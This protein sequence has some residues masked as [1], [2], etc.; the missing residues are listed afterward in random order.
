MS[1]TN[2]RS[3]QNLHESL[4]QKQQKVTEENQQEF[5]RE[6]REYIEQAKKGG[7]NISST[8]ERDQIRANLRYWANYVYS[9]DKTF[10]DT[11]LAP[12][13]IE[14]KP[15]SATTIGI[16][17]TL[18]LVITVL[19]WAG[20]F[21]FRGGSVAPAGTE[22]PLSTPTLPVEETQT[23]DPIL[24]TESPSPESPGFNVL[25]SSPANGDYITPN[26]QFTGTY[27]LKPGWAIHVLFIKGGK[28]LPV[29]DNY[30]IPESPTNNEWII[31][32]QLIE[33]E[34]DVMSQ[35]Q[36]YSIVLAVST[37][38]TDRDSLSN[39]SEDGIE[40]KS[41]PDTVLLFDKTARVIYR[42]PFTVIRQEPMLVYSLSDGSSYDLHISKPDGSYARQITFTQEFSEISPNLSP[43]GTKIVYIHKV[44]VTETHSIHIMDSNGENDREIVNG[45][46]NILE[47]PQW[48]PDGSYIAYALG[49]PTQSA[50]NAYWNIHI[51][52]LED[53]VD[54]A[55]FHESERFGQRYHT[56]LPDS[57]RIIL[58][59]RTQT[60]G[61]SGL[62]I[63]PIDVS[64]NPSLFFDLNQ[65]EISPS[66]KSLENS[67]LLTYTVVNADKSHDIYAVID[68]GK[69]VPFE[70]SQVRLTRTRAG[71]LVDGVEAANADYPIPD[72]NSN[73][74]YYRRRNNIYNVIFDIQGNS[75]I[76]RPGE[77]NDGE[78]YG[79]IVIETTNPGQDILDFDIGNMD[80]FFPIP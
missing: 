3:L 72:P 48:S 43:D 54:K 7:S 73:S 47:S 2:F 26:V 30:P 46:R 71:E 34:D 16:L 13:A 36:S 20:R 44:E 74:I 79:D 25:L 75:I 70:G 10:P 61:T 66:I 45:G 11:E 5:T 40:I 67:Y 14:S 22:T 19:A 37:N 28:Y 8:R 27:N 69:Q 33:R 15:F 64:E 39:S 17:I 52:E 18:A 49:D 21:L 80:T 63:V 42:D 51:Y 57:N 29:K 59:I 50:S 77:K 31:Q 60:T 9:L 41:L 32:T 68:P 58:N 56:W 1:E 55:I 76:L 35:A 53:Q 78:Y 4:L 38:V 62:A 12:S 65:D 24:A 23:S 6:V